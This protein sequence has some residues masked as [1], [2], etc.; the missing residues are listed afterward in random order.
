MPGRG[1]SF[2]F[3]DCLEIWWFQRF[4]CHGLGSGPCQGTETLQSEWCHQIQN[5]WWWVLF[6]HLLKFQ[7]KCWLYLTSDS[8]S[9]TLL[10]TQELRRQ[11]LIH[12]VSSSPQKL[13]SWWLPHKFLQGKYSMWSGS[14]PSREWVG[15]LEPSSNSE[16]GCL[17][18]N[19]N[20]WI[21]PVSRW[22]RVEIF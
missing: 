17:W 10:N 21:N 4:H 9:R 11:S 19:V 1:T 18:T 14:L 22:G 3:W 20:H 6:F 2:L 5:K 7:S 13:P 16:L 8:S 15:N 12:Q